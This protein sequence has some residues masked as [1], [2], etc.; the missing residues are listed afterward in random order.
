MNIKDMAG[1]LSRAGEA[2]DAALQSIKDHP[3]ADR[4][5]VGE[6]LRQYLS[7]KLLLEDAEVSDN[8]V[9]MIRL[10]ISKSSGIPVEKLK[11]MDKPGNCGSAPA[12]LTKRVMLFLEIQKVLGI[13]LP[14][15]EAAEIRTVGDLADMILL[16]M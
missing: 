10:N 5:L 1:R 6:K 12:V 3:G 7:A 16:C 14:P 11:E 13:S 2:A 8:I 15:R 4:E 9:E